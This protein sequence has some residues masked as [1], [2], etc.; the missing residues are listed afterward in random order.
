MSSCFQDNGIAQTVTEES[1]DIFSELII[2][3]TERHILDS[4]DDFTK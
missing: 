3:E 1:V 4:E 2:P